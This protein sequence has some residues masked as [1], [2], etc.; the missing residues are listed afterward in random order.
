MDEEIKYAFDAGLDFWIFNTPAR[1]LVAGNMSAGGGAWGL[2][3]NLDA[4]LTHNGTQKPNF[5]TALFGFESLGYGRSK[6]DLMMDEVVGY[7]QLPHWQTVLG[8]R[9]LLPVLFP[10]Q[11]ESS[12]VNQTGPAERMTLAEFVRHL[13]HRARAIGLRNPYIVAESAS[14]CFAD[15]AYF[16]LAGFDAMSDYQAGCG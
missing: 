12:L 1:T 4:Y 10:R 6:V 7:M 3:N 16:K 8:E 14:K 13:R 11:F 15:A 9:P 2:H 5:V